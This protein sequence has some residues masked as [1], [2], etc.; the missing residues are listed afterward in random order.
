[1]AA[2]GSMEARENARYKRTY[3]SAMSK[4]QALSNAIH[5][6]TRY[7]DIVEEEVG[8]TLL[9][10][11]CT[12]WCSSYTAVQRIVLVGT[13]KVQACQERM[14]QHPLTEDDMKF[15]DS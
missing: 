6:S 11:T 15:L 1:V 10:P 13:E 7:A 14:G 2:V 8:L 4:V 12:R 5:R 3:D 9:N